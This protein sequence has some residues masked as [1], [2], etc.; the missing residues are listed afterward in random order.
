MVPVDL[1]INLALIVWNLGA[2]APSLSLRTEGAVLNKGCLDLNVLRRHIHSLSDRQFASPLIGH[3]HNS[4][5]QYDGPWKLDGELGSG[6]VVRRCPCIS[7]ANW[8]DG[9]TKLRFARWICRLLLSY[10]P[11]KPLPRRPERQ[12]GHYR[13]QGVSIDNKSRVLFQLRRCQL[14]LWINLPLTTLQ[15]NVV[16]VLVAR[17]SIFFPSRVSF[18][19]F[20][21]HICI[22]LFS[23]VSR[24]PAMKIFW[25][26]CFQIFH[27][28]FQAKILLPPLSFFSLGV[29]WM[30]CISQAWLTSFLYLSLPLPRRSTKT[31]AMYVY[32]KAHGSS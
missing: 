23:T 28:N 26:P 2:Q 24:P 16:T 14:I 12:A 1:A 6:V 9:P 4:L 25:P 21:V 15:I 29:P 31:N 20:I 27:A 3:K 11:A 30:F 19:I 5:K 32:I 17:I 8:N 22:F 18:F 13:D 10:H 7:L